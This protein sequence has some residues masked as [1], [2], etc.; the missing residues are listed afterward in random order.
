MNMINKYKI[1]LYFL[2]QLTELRKIKQVTQ[3]KKEAVCQ[4]ER[5][6][7]GKQVSYSLVEL[8]AARSR[9]FTYTDDN[10]YF[11]FALSIGISCA[12]P[13]PIIRNPTNT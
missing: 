9:V 6:Y 4:G 1:Q 2:E 11:Y 5:A 8:D 13:Y 10:Y 12:Y 7:A 3:K